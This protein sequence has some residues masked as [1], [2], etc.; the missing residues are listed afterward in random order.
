M[1]VFNVPATTATTGTVN[2]QMLGGL[3]S[4]ALIRVSP[5]GSPQDGDASDVPF[6]VVAP[7][8]TVTAPNTNVNWTI[9]SARTITWSH[10]LGTLESVQIHV[11]RDGG[12]TWQTLSPGVANAAN[13]TGS[14]AWTVTGPATTSARIRVTWS[15]TA[16][17][18]DV[19]DVNFRIQ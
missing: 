16:T 13:T 3:T 2:I 17:V 11:S 15:A 7:A 9:G 6:N 18:N 14:F 1:R 8:I 19:S 12:A 10:N 4:Q 5:A